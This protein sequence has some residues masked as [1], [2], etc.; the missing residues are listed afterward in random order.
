MANSSETRMFIPIPDNPLNLASSLKHSFFPGD[1]PLP[2]S[3]L[4][5]RSS[6]LKDQDDV[7]NPT[8]V[9][10]TVRWSSPISDSRMIPYHESTKDIESIP[11][12]PQQITQIPW[13]ISPGLIHNESSQ[14]ENT[15][16][17]ELDPHCF[18]SLQKDRR[19]SA[20]TA[21]LSFSRPR[22]LLFRPDEFEARMNLMYLHE[23]VQP[24]ILPNS[25]TSLRRPASSRR[26]VMK[27]SQDPFRPATSI[28]IP[29]QSRSN[30]N[31]SPVRRLKRSS[32]T[33]GPNK[34]PK[35]APRTDENQFAAS[36]GITT[37]GDHFSLR[38]VLDHLT[39]PP[40]TPTDRSSAERFSSAE[41]EID[42]SDSSDDDD[43]MLRYRASLSDDHEYDDV[44]RTQR[45]Q[46]IPQIVRRPL[47]KVR[48]LSWANGL[49][50]FDYLVQN[51]KMDRRCEDEL[52]ELLKAIDVEKE[53]ITVEL[54]LETDVGKLIRSLRKCHEFEGRSRNLAERI[55]Q[56]W[57]KMC[58]A[59]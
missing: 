14:C 46:S 51:N 11:D 56:T 23:V 20:T 35:K 22:A 39:D 40:F 17:I 25:T 49:K 33:P 21:A 10:H 38:Q 29:K 12:A 9:K 13:S 19:E 44:G 52:Y 28:N 8:G 32:I 18:H 55:Y 3:T 6:P 37:D 34:R 58:R 26:R 42:D 57:R 47:T 41:P 45:P 31:D 53:K 15:T 36:D 30:E 1:S 50:R 24:K 4:Q 7:A 16:F 5:R 59:V 48:V 54:M 2:K 27:V 43:G